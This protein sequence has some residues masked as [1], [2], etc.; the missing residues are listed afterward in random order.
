MILHL[1]LWDWQKRNIWKRGWK[2][3]LIQQRTT[4][5]DAVAHSIVKEKNCNDVELINNNVFDIVLGGATQDTIGF[6][7]DIFKG[8]TMNVA[9]D[10]FKIAKA[11]SEVGS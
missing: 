2:K 9:N 1:Q 10:E 8:P 7:H 11:K 3:Q 6:Q 5:F 4:T